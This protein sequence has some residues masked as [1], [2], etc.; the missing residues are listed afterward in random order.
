MISFTWRHKNGR[1]FKFLI[2]ESMI[3]TEKCLNSILN[4]IVWDSLIWIQSYELN[5]YSFFLILALHTVVSSI[6]DAH[7]LITQPN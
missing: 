4:V 3:L 2:N 1:Q 7:Q 6:N 5:S